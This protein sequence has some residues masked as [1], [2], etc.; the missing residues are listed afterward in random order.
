MK[1]RGREVK[2]G[3]SHPELELRETLIA[4]LVAPFWSHTM[5]TRNLSDVEVVM[6]LT[7]AQSKCQNL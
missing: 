7:D 1:V 3:V 6:S 4:A 2:V 5:A